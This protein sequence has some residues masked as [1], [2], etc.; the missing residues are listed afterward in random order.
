MRIKEIVLG[1]PDEQIGFA[2]SAVANDEQFDKAV[3]PLLSLH[4]KILSILVLLTNEWN[5]QYCCMIDLFKE[6]R[7]LWSL[8]SARDLL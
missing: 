7:D 5:H 1:E 8:R 6:G 3:V 4:L 2:D